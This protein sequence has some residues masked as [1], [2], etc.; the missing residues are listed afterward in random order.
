MPTVPA[1]LT[2]AP[3]LPF[4]YVGGDPS[5]DLINTVDWTSR[6]PA[7]ERLTDYDR[8]T[9]WAEGAGLLNAR[10]GAR[11][12]AHALEHPRV[13]ERTLRDAITLRWQ[14]RQLFHAVAQG[15]PIGSVRELAEVNAALSAALSQLELVSRG[16]GDGGT[17]ALRW[18]WRDAG[19]RPDSVLWP[20]LRAAAELLASD[21][22]ARIRECGG[23]DCGWLYVDRSRNGLR[24]W[25]EMEVCGTK[26]KSRQRAL[27]RAETG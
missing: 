1:P 17:A 5:L 2:L 13:A 11:L 25:C 14:L 26:E 18:S 9:R 6:G 22:S 12:R 4:K 3:T 15:R 20:V 19:E 16:A 21:E 24:R 23:D 10:Q 27:R 8:L 7:E